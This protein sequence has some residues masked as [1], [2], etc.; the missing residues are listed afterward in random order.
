MINF[1][2]SNIQQWDKLVVDFKIRKVYFQFYSPRDTTAAAAVEKKILTRFI[3]AW[4]TSTISIIEF[5]VLWREAEQTV[6]ANEDDRG[7]SVYLIK[8]ATRT[9]IGRIEEK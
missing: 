7:N 4:A 2:P 1:D 6:G 8:G 3:D 5:D 9:G